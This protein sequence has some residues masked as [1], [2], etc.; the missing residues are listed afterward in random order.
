MIN[1]ENKGLDM[2]TSWRDLEHVEK[3]NDMYPRKGKLVASPGP[4]DSWLLPVGGNPER[5]RGE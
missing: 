1:M 2:K 3:I 4:N 5:E